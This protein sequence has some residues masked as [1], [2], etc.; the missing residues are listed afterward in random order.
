MQT[1]PNSNG[2]ASVGVN[3]GMTLLCI[4]PTWIVLS[5]LKGSA[6]VREDGGVVSETERHSEAMGGKDLDEDREM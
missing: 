3:F 2:Y 6:E 4:V 1:A 5:E